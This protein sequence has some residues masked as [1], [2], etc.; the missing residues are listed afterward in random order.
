MDEPKRQACRPVGYPPDVRYIWTL[1]DGRG[2]EHPHNPDG[3]PFDQDPELAA[4]AE[5]VAA[6]TAGEPCPECGEVHR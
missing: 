6:S 3:C 1:L 4:A 5:E 2:I